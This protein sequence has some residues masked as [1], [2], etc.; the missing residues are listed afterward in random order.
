MARF[1]F[2]INDSTA[3]TAEVA[4]AVFGIRVGEIASVYQLTAG[5]ESQFYYD[6]GFSVEKLAE[7]NNGPLVEMCKA[8]NDEGEL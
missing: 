7:F 6:E 2:D 5:T 4:K 3:T 8:H 1:I